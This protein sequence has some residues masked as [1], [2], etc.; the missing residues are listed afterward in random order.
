MINSYFLEGYVKLPREK[1]RRYVRT[2]NE[3]DSL[4]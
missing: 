4:T 3:R 2:R 1:K